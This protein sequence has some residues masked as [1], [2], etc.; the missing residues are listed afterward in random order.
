MA[1]FA[2]EVVDQGERAINA[3]SLVLDATEHDDGPPNAETSTVT[4]ASLA[5]IFSGLRVL[6]GRTRQPK[7][8]QL[9]IDRS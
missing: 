7:L 5:A 8:A 3:N 2:G 6:P 1:A 9:T 4:A